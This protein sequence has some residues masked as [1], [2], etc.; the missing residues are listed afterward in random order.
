MDDPRLDLVHSSQWG[1]VSRREGIRG[2]PRLPSIL[3]IH[4]LLVDILLL[5]HLGAHSSFLDLDGNQAQKRCHHKDY[6]WDNKRGQHERSGGNRNFGR[7]VCESI[8]RGDAKA[9]IREDP[10]RVR[11][12]FNAERHHQQ[13]LRPLTSPCSEHSR[14]FAGPWD[15]LDQ[16]QPR[17]PT[18]LNPNLPRKVP[19]LRPREV[20]RLSERVRILRASEEVPPRVRPHFPHKVPRVLDENPSQLPHL[21]EKLPRAVIQEQKPAWE[22]WPGEAVR[23]QPRPSEGYKGKHPSIWRVCKT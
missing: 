22:L 14:T 12:L 1:P 17:F 6:S 4:G 3:L 16:E 2:L 11:D 19:G 9:G 5:R 7:C 15:V 23:V 13:F 8:G 18:D 21:P 10:A 20:L